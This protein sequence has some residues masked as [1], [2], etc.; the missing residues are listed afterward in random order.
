MPQWIQKG[1]TTYDPV[2]SRTYDSHQVSG[3]AGTS[4]FT[5]SGKVARR[6]EFPFKTPYAREANEFVRLNCP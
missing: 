3:F 5:L 1:T 6:I 2:A 4:S